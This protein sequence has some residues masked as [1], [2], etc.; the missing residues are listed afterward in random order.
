MAKSAGPLPLAHHETELA[1]VA[2]YDYHL[3]ASSSQVPSPSSS[4]FGLPVVCRP[5]PR[6]L[7]RISPSTTWEFC[8][9]RKSA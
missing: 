9:E 2:S 1:T 4:L 5:N 6:L 8:P 7:S 3:R